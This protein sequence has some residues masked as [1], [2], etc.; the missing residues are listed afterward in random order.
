MVEISF[1]VEIRLQRPGQ[2]PTERRISGYSC[3]VT[4]KLEAALT[5][6]DF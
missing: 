6:S 2:N 4:G 3:S 1:G 5:F